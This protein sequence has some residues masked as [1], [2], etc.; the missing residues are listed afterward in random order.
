MVDEWGSGVGDAIGG[1]DPPNQRRRPADPVYQFVTGP[2]P[3]ALKS[4]LADSV[5]HPAD[6]WRR[7]KHNTMLNDQRQPCVCA[8]VGWARPT[9]FL[10]DPET[11]SNDQRQPCVRAIVGW[12]LPTVFLSDPETMSN[13]QRQPCVRAIVSMKRLFVVNS[14]FAFSAFSSGVSPL[15]GG[16]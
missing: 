9:I 3:G 6:G 15:S 16:D 4:S 1:M 13:D 10:S 11:M 14:C 5:L 8:I 12:A 2:A 7:M